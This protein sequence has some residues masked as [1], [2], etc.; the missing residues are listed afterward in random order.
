M[1]IPIFLSSDDNYSPFV[2]TTIAS[3]CDNTKS[4]IDFYILDSFISEINKEKILE[5]KKSFN[6]FNIEFIKIDSDKEF[7]DIAYTNSENY[8]SISTYNRFLIPKLKPQLKK[9]LYLDVDIVALG[10]IKELYDIDMENYI[11]GAAWAQ[12]R[13]HYCLDTSHLVD[14]SEDYRYFNAGVLLIDVQKWI[15]ND[16]TKKLF[17]I[18]KKYRNKILHAD[19][20]LL[21]KYFDLNYKAFD[22]K[23]NYLD[24]DVVTSPR[25]NIV[26]RHFASKLKPWSFGPD[27]NVNDIS[28]YTDTKNVEDFWKYAKITPF[29][30][31]IKSKYEFSSIK[32]LYKYRVY[33]LF[34]KRKNISD[35]KEK[36]L[37]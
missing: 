5:L 21:N 7:S 25:D 32:E 10:D 26:I 22:I 37:N 31:V 4:N 16:V 29:L 18:E 12:N 15:E 30:D 17:D 28:K 36:L 2:A 1:N 6:N 23:Y 13:K 24:F 14:L 35:K 34:R 9:V 19:E 33:A 3:I 27:I 20:T 8:I 11:L